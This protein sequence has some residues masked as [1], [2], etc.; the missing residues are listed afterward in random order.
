M[1]MASRLSLQAALAVWYVSYGRQSLLLYAVHHLPASPACSACFGPSC[2]AQGPTL[3][4]PSQKPSNRLP[5]DRTLKQ[6]QSDLSISLLN[7]LSSLLCQCREQTSQP[8][9][10][11]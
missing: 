9:N 1:Y 2:S 7:R 6:A 11:M 4:L 3:G 5:C 8:S 10:L